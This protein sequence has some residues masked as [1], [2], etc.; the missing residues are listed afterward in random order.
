MLRTWRGG[1]ADTNRDPFFLF[2]YFLGY[3]PL[4]LV[5]LLPSFQPQL[6]GVF[7]DSEL[8]GILKRDEAG[9]MGGQERAPRLKITDSVPAVCLAG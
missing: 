7:L 1:V 6:L 5:A 3:G 2:L 4:K 8:C 9:T